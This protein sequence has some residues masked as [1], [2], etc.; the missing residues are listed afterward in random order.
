MKR[1][2]KRLYT[3]VPGG[4]ITCIDSFLNSLQLPTLKE[5]H[6]N[7]LIA[8]IT[9]NELLDTISKLKVGKSPGSDGYT[10]EWYKEFK[11]ELVPILLPT[12]NWTLEKS[13]IPPSW[14]EAIISACLLL[15]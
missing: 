10:A 4:N 3:R 1:S 6:N 2:I 13:Q 14:N 5:E 12:L 15:F 8:E 7:S 9:A 11:T